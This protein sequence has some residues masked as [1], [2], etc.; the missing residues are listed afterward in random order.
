MDT[1]SARSRFNIYGQKVYLGML[2]HGQ[3]HRHIHKLLLELSSAIWTLITY[4][5][6]SI[7][8][9]KWTLYLLDVITM[10]SILLNG[11]LILALLHASHVNKTISSSDVAIINVC[12]YSGIRFA[13]IYVPNHASSVCI[14][15]FLLMTHVCH[16]VWCNMPLY[17]L[18]CYCVLY[19]CM[20][21]YPITY[22]T[23]VVIV[24]VFTGQL[25]P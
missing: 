14:T 9:Y 10:M 11:T 17:I 21:K 5:R 8:S 20:Y 6:W 13:P 18:A 12:I 1:G 3:L 25:R 22:G 16:V 2:H 7:Y 15:I 4:W 19:V 24:T 23:Y